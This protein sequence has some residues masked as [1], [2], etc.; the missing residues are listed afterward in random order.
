LGRRKRLSI[1]LALFFCSVFAVLGIIASHEADFLP[2]S[3]EREH[4]HLSLV[5]IS[6]A[7]GV[8]R[9]WLENQQIQ[10]LRDNGKFSVSMWNPAP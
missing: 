1:R 8:Q 4:D 9:C 2:A 6:L 5:L 10:G 7:E 3:K